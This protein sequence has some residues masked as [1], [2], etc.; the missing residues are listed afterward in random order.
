MA[1][2]VMKFLHLRPE[3][4]WYDIMMIWVL[5]G[6][7]EVLSYLVLSLRLRVTSAQ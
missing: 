6:L 5:H 4:L 2:A 7:Y 1:D 3:E